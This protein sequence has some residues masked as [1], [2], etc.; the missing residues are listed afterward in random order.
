MWWL[1]LVAGLVIVVLLAGWRVGRYQRD[2][3]DELGRENRNPPSFNPP[4]FH[5]RAGPH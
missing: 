2:I 3:D 5:D 4:P 1:L